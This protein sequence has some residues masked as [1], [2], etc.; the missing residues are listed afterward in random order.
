MIV[1]NG[2]GYG[3][4]SYRLLT[5]SFDIVLTSDAR[6]TLKETRL[7]DNDVDLHGELNPHTICD[8]WTEI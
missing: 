2:F 1:L 3:V 8:L 7:S 4:N 5:T 6:F